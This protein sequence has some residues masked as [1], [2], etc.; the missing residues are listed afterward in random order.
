MAQNTFHVAISVKDL[1][2]AIEQYTKMLGVAPAKVK[3]D[4]A[5]FE[6]A[7][8]PAIISLNLGGEPGTVSHLGIRYADT[9]TV[10]RELARTKAQGVAVR[11][12]PGT[13]CCYAKADKFWVRDA[14]GLEWE[15]Y[16]LLED[17]EVHSIME[18]P[19]DVCCSPTAA[20]RGAVQSPAVSSCCAPAMNAPAESSLVQIQAKRACG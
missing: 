20:E 15:M 16:N 2:S 11:E 14:D 1:P 19:Q 18:T 5:K 9:E 6:L 8:P 13:T 3:P 12:Q 7:D 4:Y 10:A 17:A